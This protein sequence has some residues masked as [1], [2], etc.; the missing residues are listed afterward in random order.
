MSVSLYG[1]GQTVI[2]VVSANLSTSISTTS[3]SYVTTGLTASITPQNTTSKILVM[4]SGANIYNGSAAVITTIY[5][6]ATN[7]GT[8]DLS[9]LGIWYAGTG[10]GGIVM[11]YLDSP[12]TTSS[13]TYT[14]YFAANGGGT[15][16]FSNQNT[17]S[18]ITLLEISGS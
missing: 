8:G 17:L 11:Q 18:S 15:A 2:Q 14:V 9:S 10:Q 16:I 5:R 1:S 3:G 12:A 7:L 13:T 4:V 6:G